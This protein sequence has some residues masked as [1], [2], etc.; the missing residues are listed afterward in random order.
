[1]RFLVVGY[2]LLLAVAS[3]ANA[4]S[5]ASDPVIGVWINADRSA[6]VETKACGRSLCAAVVW[7]SAEAVRKAKKA[8]TDPLLGVELLSDYQRK[9]SG[10]WQGQVFVPDMNRH[11]F[12]RIEPAG[13]NRMKLSGCVLSGLICK[14]TLWTRDNPMA[15]GHA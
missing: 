15:S 11:F 13:I 8:G 6:K 4:S 5:A 12:S 7:A 3:A 1:M 14:S 10:I 2:S 9:A